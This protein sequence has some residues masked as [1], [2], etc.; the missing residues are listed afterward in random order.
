MH[1]DDMVANILAYWDSASPVQR[2]AGA[3]WYKD[4][5]RLAEAIGL[6]TGIDTHR[7]VMAISALSPRNPWRWN[8]FD[9]FSYCVARSEGRTMPKATTYK[10]N[11][12]A[13]WRALD[14][15]TETPWYTAA[16]KVR[17]FVAALLGDEGS[18]VVDTWAVRVATGGS[19]SRVESDKAY[20][21]YAHAYNVAA[22]LRDVPPATMQ[23]TTWLVAQQEG[24]ATMR[25]GRHDLA[26]KKGTPAWLM[27]V[28]LQA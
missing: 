21:A 16:P 15:N 1:H 2:E 4:A 7:V 25:R 12:A 5:G 24:L 20:K 26:F 9:A 23:A 14:P 3:R 11:Q 18:V 27:S 8:V 17:S 10:R 13:A 28:L 6:L 19:K 22:N